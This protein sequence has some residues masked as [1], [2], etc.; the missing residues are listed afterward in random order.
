MPAGNNVFIKLWLEVLVLSSC[1]LLQKRGQDFKSNKGSLTAKNPIITDLM[2]LNLIKSNSKVIYIFEQSFS[3]STIRNDIF[4]NGYPSDKNPYYTILFTQ[5]YSRLNQMA[6]LAWFHVNS[7]SGK[8]M[9]GDDFQKPKK[10][11]TLEECTAKK[12]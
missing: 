9:V 4:I 5:Y 1:Y 10:K 11:Y 3:D 8:V 7:Y 2:A 6:V 12:Q